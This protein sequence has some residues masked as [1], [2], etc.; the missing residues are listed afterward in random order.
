MTRN[1]NNLNVENRVFA[2]DQKHQRFA[3]PYIITPAVEITEDEAMPTLKDG[4]RDNLA[5]YHSALAAS[6]LNKG[7]NAVI[8]GTYDNLHLG[9]ETVLKTARSL[10][11]T[12][13]VGVESQASA[14]E[15][16]KNKHS[17]MGDD[18]RLALVNSFGLTAKENVFIRQHALQ[19]IIDLEQ[20]GIEMTTLI[21]GE[22][23]NDNQEIVEAVEYCMS[24]GIQVI[25]ATRL[26]VSNLDHEISSS[27]I[28]KSGVT[29][30]GNKYTPQ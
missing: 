30:N 9:H 4:S 2:A 6:D 5:A 12:L 29:R 18:E 23:Q 22:S 27:A 16:K 24:K 11:D 13:Y 14:S 25:A 21:V 10:C 3:L 20:N 28:H 8:F 19:D 15:R 17:I 1:N 7:G 26:R